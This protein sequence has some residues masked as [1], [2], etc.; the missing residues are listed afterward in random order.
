MVVAGNLTMRFYRV[1]DDSPRSFCCYRQIIFVVRYMIYAS[2]HRFVISDSI[3]FDRSRPAAPPS[4]VFVFSDEVCFFLSCRH[5]APP[6]MFFLLLHRNPSFCICPVSFF[7]F[8]AAVSEPRAGKGG[9]RR[10]LDQPP[11][12]GGSAK[13]IAQGFDEEDAVAVDQESA[14]HRGN[15]GHQVTPRAGLCL[16]WRAPCGRLEGRTDGPPGR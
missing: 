16:C 8:C 15:A 2:I 9:K 13:G 6:F 11:T 5:D 3:A 14:G 10:R 12:F 1:R 4:T 7:V